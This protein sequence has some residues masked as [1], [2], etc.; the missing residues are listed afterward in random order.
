MSNLFTHRGFLL[1]ALLSLIG[2]IGLP[3]VSVSLSED[4]EIPEPPTPFPDS[5]GVDPVATLS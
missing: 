5:I 3:V 2:L 4:V 1:V